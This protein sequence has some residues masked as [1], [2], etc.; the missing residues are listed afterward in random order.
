MGLFGSV[1]RGARR[2]KGCFSRPGGWDP[3][4]GDG[5]GDFF[6]GHGVD[7]SLEDGICQLGRALGYCLKGGAKKQCGR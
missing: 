7:L 1:D 6:G 2:W 5:E 3:G 4:I